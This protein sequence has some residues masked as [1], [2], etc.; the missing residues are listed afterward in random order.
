MQQFKDSENYIRTQKR[1][2][3]DKISGAK[4]RRILMND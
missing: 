2:G 3:D 4:F 1:N